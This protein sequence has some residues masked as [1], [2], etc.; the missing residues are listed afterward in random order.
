MQA[1]R[2]VR[3]RGLMAKAPPFENLA[4]SIRRGSES[5]HRRVSLNFECSDHGPNPR[6]VYASRFVGVVF[7]GGLFVYT[8]VIVTITCG[9]VG[10][11]SLRVSVNV[12]DLACGF[13]RGVNRLF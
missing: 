3:L 13:A 9:R 2:S 8:L 4:N 7:F 5:T 10:G 1:S 11:C 6:E 12:L